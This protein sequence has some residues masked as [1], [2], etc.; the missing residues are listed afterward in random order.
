MKYIVTALGVEASPII[1]RF[2]LKK[3]GALPFGYYEGEEIALIVSGVGYEN[4]LMATAAL[5][6]KHQKKGELYNIG[7]CAAPRRYALG[8]LLH[9][10]EIRYESSRFRCAN[11]AGVALLTCKEACASET[12]CAVDMEA[13]AIFK[14]AKRFLP[15]EKLHFM[16]IVSDHFEP[17]T[18]SKAGVAQ[19]IRAQMDAIEKIVRAQKIGL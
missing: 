15:V 16:K 18:V 3:S 2:G 5:L 6:A 10:S 13:H 9:V 11:S 8:S 19:M 4:A 7:I 12:E 14:A 1:E 17:H